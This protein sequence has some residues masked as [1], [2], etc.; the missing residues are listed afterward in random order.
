MYK[1]MINLF[2]DDVR[3]ITYEPNYE[4][5]YA[6]CD[7]VHKLISGLENVWFRQVTQS[8]V[9]GYLITALKIYSVRNLRSYRLRLGIIT[10]RISQLDDAAVSFPVPRYF[11]DVF[12]EFTRPME[13]DLDIYIPDIVFNS[14][15]PFSE[16]HEDLPD[17]D[18]ISAVFR[19]LNHVSN[20]FLVPLDIEQTKP[21]PISFYY[22]P[23]NVLLSKTFLPEWRTRAVTALKHCRFKQSPTPTTQIDVISKIVNDSVSN[24]LQGVVV[25]RNVNGRR[26][27]RT[28]VLRYNPPPLLVETI[29]FPT[30]EAGVYSHTPPRRSG[31]PSTRKRQVAKDQLDVKDE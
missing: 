30:E 18:R 10:D 31:K 4:S 7:S 9:R 2:D 19:A 8:E 15:V 16:Y 3:I 12:R 11:R 23:E 26:F 13:D 25:N 6:L 17:F 1:S 28:E 24:L 20:R 29:R 14:D 22:E 21:A 27:F 5:F